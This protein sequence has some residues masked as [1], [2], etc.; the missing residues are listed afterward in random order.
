M[1][2]PTMYYGRTSGIGRILGSANLPAP[3]RVGVVGLGTGTLAAYARPGDFYR[4]YEINPLVETLARRRFTWLAGAAGTVDVV[5]G[6]ARLSLSRE[7]PQAYDVLVVDAFNGDA[8]P[9]HLLTREAVALYRRHLAPGGVIAVHTSNRYLMLE[10]VV[11]AVAAANG[12]MAHATETEAD[13]DRGL[14]WNAWVLLSDSY[15]SLVPPDLWRA[16]VR[17]EPEPGIATW[18]DER[19]SLWQVLVL[20]AAVTQP[21]GS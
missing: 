15:T 2:E 17:I 14:A 11:Q 12:L 19:S 9:V 1:R 16:C 21:N 13:P 20:P 4:F 6:D 5:L 7:P 3:V 8:V 10:P 18:T